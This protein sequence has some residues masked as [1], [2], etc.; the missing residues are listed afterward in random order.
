MTSRVKCF[1]KVIGDGA[2]G[3]LGEKVAS[4]GEG[5]LVSQEDYKY[6]MEWPSGYG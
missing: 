5:G 1:C 6:G 4:I 2:I 3:D